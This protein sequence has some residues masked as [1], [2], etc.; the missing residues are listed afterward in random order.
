MENSYEKA[1]NILGL[2]QTTNED[3]I[4]A[5]YERL[6]RKGGT[7]KQLWEWKVAHQDCLAFLLLKRDEV[8]PDVQIKSSEIKIS[9]EEHL[10]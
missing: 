10:N 3:L 5:T 8:T 2:E 1:F 6:L 7:E 9:N 4:N